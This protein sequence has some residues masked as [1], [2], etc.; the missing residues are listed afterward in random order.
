M[1]KFATC[2][3]LNMFKKAQQ[4]LTVCSCN[5]ESNSNNQADL[6]AGTELPRPNFVSLQIFNSAYFNCSFGA[7]KKQLFFF[8]LN[9]SA[10]SDCS[11]H[12]C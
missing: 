3:S 8:L 10:N 12:L 4:M 5:S 6:P 1:K 2:F 11:F 9:S 7:E